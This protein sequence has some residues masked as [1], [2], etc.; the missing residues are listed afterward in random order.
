M[1]VS[2]ASQRVWSSGCCVRSLGRPF[3]CWWR[4]DALVSSC[5]WVDAFILKDL[6][7]KP[8][9]CYCWFNNSYC[10]ARVLP[11]SDQSS[12]VEHGGSDV[13]HP[14]LQLLPQR[15]VG[16]AG[17]EIVSGGAGLPLETQNHQDRLGQGRQREKR[18]DEGR[19]EREVTEQLKRQR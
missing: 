2:S 8:Y 5:M 4:W 17:Q 15:L 13:P 11:S 19:S 9:C 12:E 10:N 6:C 7:W 18:T 14:D 16:G 1:C 3:T